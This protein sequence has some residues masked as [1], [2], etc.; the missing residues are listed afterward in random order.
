MRYL[1]TELIAAVKEAGDEITT[2]TSQVETY[3]RGFNDC[4]AFVML[5]DE[6][7][8]G[9]TKSKDI[10]D[11]DWKNSRDFIVKLN[12]RGFSLSDFATYCGY[13]I[14]TN[15]RPEL[16]DIA[17]QDGSAMIAGYENMWIST[18][19]KN[20]GLTQRQMMFFERKLNLLCRPRK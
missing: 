15:G 19:E 7:L 14:I 11:F 20:T 16:G 3:K 4:F 13:D 2:R 8:R 17:F 12:R 18:C 6:K 5:Y 9:T 1:Y 10:V